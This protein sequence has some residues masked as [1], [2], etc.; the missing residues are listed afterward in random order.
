MAE[1]DISPSAMAFLDAIDHEAEDADLERRFQSASAVC[2]VAAAGEGGAGAC[3]SL[4]DS[5]DLFEGANATGLQTGTELES[6]GLFA[7]ATVMESMRLLG[8]GLEPI[9]LAALSIAELEEV[10][11]EPCSSGLLELRKVAAAEVAYE[12]AGRKENQFKRI[13][14]AQQPAL[15]R[16]VK[17]KKPAAVDRLSA[18]YPPCFSF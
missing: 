3:G 16:R 14:P 10:I 8:V 13:F 7:G 12:A 4:Q 5:L 9:D 1:T 17:H 6:E 15:D 18:R 11:G 2:G